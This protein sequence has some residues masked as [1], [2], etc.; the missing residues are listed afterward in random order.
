M[1]IDTQYFSDDLDAMIADLGAVLRYG[2]VTLDCSITDLTQDQALLLTGVDGIEAITATFTFDSAD[3]MSAELTPNA[4]VLIRRPGESAWRN[5]SIV[6]VVNPNDNESYAL[7]C[8]A[9]NRTNVNFIETF[10][11]EAMVS[12]AGNSLVTF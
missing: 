6:T 3:G 12:F 7:V 11:D 10:N 5:Y 2:G 1:A 9:D 4:R 8:K